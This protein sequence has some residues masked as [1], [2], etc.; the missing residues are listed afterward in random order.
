MGTLSG[1][2]TWCLVQC[3]VKNQS[4]IK[5]MLSGE[6][7]IWGAN[8]NSFTDLQSTGSLLEMS[9]QNVESSLSPNFRL[10]NGIITSIWIGSRCVDMMTSYTSSKKAIKMKN[11]SL[12][13]TRGPRDEEK[14]KSQSQQALQRRRRPRPL[15]KST[16]GS[17][18]HQKTAS[19]SAPAEEPMQTTQDL[20]E[21]SHQ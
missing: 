13:Q 11:P 15:A 18:S 14:E 7:L 8:V 10:S 5:N 12:D 19:N 1:L 20:E 4:A 21:P 16:Q 17:K 6:S 2:K 3:G 9:T